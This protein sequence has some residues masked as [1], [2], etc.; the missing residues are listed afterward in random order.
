MGLI[1]RLAE[2]YA[3]SGTVGILVGVV[4][5]IL[6]VCGCT[7]V[8]T[9]WRFRLSSTSYGNGGRE[10]KEPPTLPY[11]IPWLGNLLEYLINPHRFLKSAM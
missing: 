5:V 7:F 1:H 6:S 4:A 9:T 8:F 3:G 10:G 2:A 11:Y